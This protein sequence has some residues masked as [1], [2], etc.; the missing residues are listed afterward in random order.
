MS[1]RTVARLQLIGAA[2]LFSTGGAAIKAVSFTGWQIAGLRS[3]VAGVAILVLS[4][5]ARRWGGWTWRAVLVGAAYAI[6]LTLF[7][8]AN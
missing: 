2:V 6:C 7:V 3:G 4:R 5:E 1:P 8:L